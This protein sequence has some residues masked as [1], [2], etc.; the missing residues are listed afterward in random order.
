LTRAPGTSQPNLTRKKNR[1]NNQ[2]KKYK[3]TK[4]D[5]T[6]SHLDYKLYFNKQVSLNENLVR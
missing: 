1:V 2:Q 5:V 4:H 3:Q 6:T